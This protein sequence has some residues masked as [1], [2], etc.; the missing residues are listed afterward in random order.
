M[1]KKVAYN[2]VAY[3]NFLNLYVKFYD[4]NFTMVI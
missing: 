2:I 3:Y 4:R 1:N